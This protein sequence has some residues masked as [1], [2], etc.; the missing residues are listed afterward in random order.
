MNKISRAA[1]AAL[2]LLLLTGCAAPARTPPLPTTAPRPAPTTFALVVKSL[3]NPY[4]KTMA[5]G[6]RAACLEL[7]IQAEVVGPGADGTPGQAKLSAGLIERRVAAIAVA[8]NDMDEVDHRADGR[9]HP[10]GGR[11]NRPRRVLR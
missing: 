6:F 10:R 7:G 8:A 2:L 11:G 9:R 3:E 5:S 4:M 1:C